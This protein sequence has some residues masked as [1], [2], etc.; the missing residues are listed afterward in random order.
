MAFDHFAREK[1]D[2]AIIE[3]GMGGRLDSTNI[4]TPLLSLITNISIDHAEFLGNTEVLI[5]REKGGIIKPGVP[6]IVGVNNGDIYNVFEQIAEEKKSNILFASDSREFRFQTFTADQ[7]ALFHFYNRQ[8]GQP[9]VVHSDL[10]GRYQHENI[11]LAMAATDLLR[12]SGWKLPENAVSKGMLHVKSNTGLRGRWEIL[13]T[14]PRIIADTAH[15]R[16]GVRAVMGQLKEVPARRLHI[17]WGMVG[18]K[19]I[20]AIFQYLLQ[21]AVYYFTQPS[22]PR[23]MPVDRLVA[24]A[25]TAGLKGS[26]FATVAT[27][28]A[29]AVHAAKPDD[30]I[31]V[32]GSTFVVAD[33]LQTFRP[34]RG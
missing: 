30:T 20:D 24:T 25:R 21:E 33:F 11:N 10:S 4:V 12:E 27:A 5:A 8:T 15:N 32:G 18:D 16:E 13:G 26:A 28:F 3:T 31:F 6:V 9:E 23:A 14:N 22:I 7:T 2:I 29:A 1:V 17:V 34:Y 19:P